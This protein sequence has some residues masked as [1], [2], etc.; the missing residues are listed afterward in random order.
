MN[1]SC[2]T[3]EWGMSHKRMSR[4]THTDASRHTHEWAMS[5]IWMSHITH[6]NES[7]TL[8]KWLLVMYACVMSHI[9]MRHTTH[10]DGSCHTHEWVMTH[11]YVW[12]VSF[13]WVTCPI[14]TSPEASW[15][16][17]GVGRVGRLTPPTPQ[18]SPQTV[19]TFFLS[20]LSF[21]DPI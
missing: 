14:H 4:I 11:P 13:I 21:K 17:C 6:M 10:V 18:A 2:H 9:W 16:A 20:S 7:W 5:H 3:Y 1:E 19:Q 8:K 12:H 15:G